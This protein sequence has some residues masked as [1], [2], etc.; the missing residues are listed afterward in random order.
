MKSVIQ[1][2]EMNP[3]EAAKNLKSL[4]TRVKSGEFEI[5]KLLVAREEAGDFGKGEMNSYA[6]R[7]TGLELRREIQ[8][9]YE[10]C[11]VLRAIRAG[12]I[13]LTESEFDKAKKYCLIKLA[14]LIG[15]KDAE[16][17][18]AA[19]EIIRSGKDVTSRIKALFPKKEKPESKPKAEKEPKE[20]EKV[21][22]LTEIESPESPKGDSYFVPEGTGILAV[23]EIQARILH[24]MR[25]APYVASCEN[26]HEFLKGLVAH[27][28]TRWEVLEA[29]A[30]TP[31]KEL[32]AA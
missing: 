26:Y 1:F 7:V 20:P 28:H 22:E 2:K 29:E 23:E 5:M 27:L 8:G 17:I 30:Q 16:K 14:S 10:G 12:D 21:I 9:V 4:C 13:T 19:V 24:D 15:K 31:A 25:T 32:Q 6:Q 11:T 18:T 3:N